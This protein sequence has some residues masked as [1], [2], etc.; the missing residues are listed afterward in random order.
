LRAIRRLIPLER[1]QYQIVEASGD[2]MIK[3]QVIARYLTLDQQ[4]AETPAASVAITRDNYKFHYKN[5]VQTEVGRAYIFEVT[6]RKKRA[7]L[8][9]GELWLDSETGIPVRLSGHFVKTPSLFIKRIEMTRDLS[10]HDG[11]VQARTTRLSI[12][13][14]LAGTAEVQVLEQPH[15]DFEDTATAPEQP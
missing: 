14:R 3:Q 9:K 15:A 11:A 7:G 13:T 1:P 12:K 6:P 5:I 2:Q 8:I 10:I 4:A